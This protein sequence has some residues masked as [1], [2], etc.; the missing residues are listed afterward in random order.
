MCIRDRVR[1]VEDNNIESAESFTMMLLP[2]RRGQDFVLGQVTST[3]VIISDDDALRAPNFSFVESR[4]SRTPRTRAYVH[5]FDIPA[6]TGDAT[7]TQV[8]LFLGVNV[9]T[10][11]DEVFTLR[12]HTDNLISTERPPAGTWSSVPATVTIPSGQRAVSFSFTLTPGAATADRFF[13]TAAPGDNNDYV[14]G[15]APTAEIG[16]G[17]TPRGQQH[18]DIIPNTLTLEQG[19][20]V[21]FGI[22]NYPDQANAGGGEPTGVLTS[23]RAADA[24]PPAIAAVAPT[25]LP[26]GLTLRWRSTGADDDGRVNAGEPIIF[27]APADGESLDVTLSAAFTAPP[28]ASAPLL[29]NAAFTATGAVDSAGDPVTDVV[30]SICLL[31]TS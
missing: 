6:L 11:K 28:R 31:Y 7:T 14:A 3:V 24:G 1:S 18:L 16:V 27:P 13:I 5:P 21:A 22:Y 20:S 26:E 25:N 12:A 17:F 8:E 15:L 9:A 10:T 23:G 30:F 29:D 19:G 2:P 4:T